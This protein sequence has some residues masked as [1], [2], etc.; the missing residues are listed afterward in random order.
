MTT[1]QMAG[2]QL[3]AG[4]D[5]WRFSLALYARPGVAAALLALQDRD[6]RNVNLILFALWQGIC[7]F[8]LDVQQLA[9][10]K[11][12]VARLSTETVSPLRALRRRLKDP[13]D[14]DLAA[15]RRRILAL[16][17]E[18]ER[19]MQRHLAALAAGWADAGPAVGSLALAEANLALYLGGKAPSA[20]AAIV[21]RALT[22]LTRGG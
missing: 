12:A 1:P 5:F 6:R 20:E 22:A 13:R 18:G 11:A 15:L 17:L 2:R 4:E 14:A 7:G 10:A 9:A 16:E 21:L 3:R 8:P 19:R